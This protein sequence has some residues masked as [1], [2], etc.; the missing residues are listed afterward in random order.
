MPYIYCLSNPAMPGLLKFGAVHI[1]GKTVKDRAIELYDSGVPEEF[2]IEFF[3]AVSDSRGTESKI[4]SLLEKYRPN[5]SREFFRIEA[6]DAKYMIEQH[7]PELLWGD[8]ASM[9]STKVSKS[10]Y[11]RLSDL[12]TIVSDDVCRFVDMIK[13]HKYYEEYDYDSP[14]ENR[15]KMLMQR[16]QYMH[17]ALNRMNDKE[18]IES[19]HRNS[20]N[21][22]MRR[23]MHDIQRDLEKLKDSIKSCMSNE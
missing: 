1:N 15:C 17:E 22:Y 14:N 3:A 11:I 18:A 12:Y 20:D 9:H 16:L 19:P 13:K 4:H 21:A 5:R 8:N 6:E 7:I 23:E 10:A 2:H